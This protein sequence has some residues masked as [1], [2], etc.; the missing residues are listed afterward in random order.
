[1]A[2]TMPSDFSI[3]QVFERAGLSRRA[4]LM[5]REYMRLALQRP[6]EMRTAINPVISFLRDEIGR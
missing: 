2:E 4:A 5:T 3:R 6:V 1:M